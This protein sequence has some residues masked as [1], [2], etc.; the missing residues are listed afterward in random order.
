M[1][2]KGKNPAVVRGIGIL[3]VRGAGWI[4][5]RM[6]MPPFGRRRA[7]TLLELLV[8]VSLLAILVVMLMSMVDNAT[9]LWRV[10]ESRVESYREARAALNLMMNDLKSL[11]AS[12]NA[13]LFQ[14]NA[15]SPFLAVPGGGQLFFIAALPAS[16]QDS[17]SRSDLCEVGYFLKYGQ[18]GLN[19]DEKNFS[20][21]R[22]F[23]ESNQTFTNLVN[24][25]GFFTHST[26]NVELLA[27][28]IPNFQVR[29]YTVS[30][31]GAV[32]PWTAVSSNAL[33]SFV[34]LQ[35]TAFNNQTAKRFNSKE[36]W[37]NAASQTYRESSRVFT[38]R[39]PL[40]PPG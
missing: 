38:A 6:P 17:G 20:L 21:Y 3:P 37:T 31:N 9:K 39:I 23:R 4:I 14:T 34:E 12:T 30:T 7:F 10:N 27:R 40:R 5:G 19:P 22:Y 33:P 2:A 15:A 11:Y 36:D 28:N 1:S 32:S 25:S 24:N 8:A 26:A 16:A 18:S 35:I 29:Y 13:N